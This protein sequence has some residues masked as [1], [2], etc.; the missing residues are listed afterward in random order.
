MYIRLYSKDSKPHIVKQQGTMVRCGNI[1]NSNCFENKNS[2]FLRYNPDKEKEF[3]D[4]DTGWHFQTLLDN[5]VESFYYEKCWVGKT[6][7]VHDKID[8]EPIEYKIETKQDLKELR[9]Y[10]LNHI[11]NEN[12]DE[13]DE[14]YYD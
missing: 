7:W 3:S 9:A 14:M 10:I 13:P 2:I 1:Y 8:D 4:T 6:Y 11:K 5:Y 12:F